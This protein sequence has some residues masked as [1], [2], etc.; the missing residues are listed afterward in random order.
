MT[1]QPSLIGI[2]HVWIRR[3]RLTGYG[4]TP[5]EYIPPG[6]VGDMEVTETST[7]GRVIHARFHPAD[8]QYVG[9]GLVTWPK[10]EY[11]AGGD[12]A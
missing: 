5:N 11:V 6:T 3:V 7:D 10:W 1:G 2:C 4:A 8:E 12:S 9:Y